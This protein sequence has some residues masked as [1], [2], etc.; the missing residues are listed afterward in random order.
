MGV[1][2]IGEERD[3]KC[4]GQKWGGGCQEASM[5]ESGTPIPLSRDTGSLMLRFISGIFKFSEDSTEKTHLLGDDKFPLCRFIR[6]CIE[7][8][9]RF[10][11]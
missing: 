8:D 11:W 10:F 5:S 6:T 4:H 2:K 1:R 3:G 9:H 7:L